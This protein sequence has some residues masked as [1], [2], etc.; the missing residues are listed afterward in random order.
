MRQPSPLSGGPHTG[1]G[2]AASPRGPGTETVE[3]PPEGPL[4]AGVVL[5]S[6]KEPAVGLP[7]PLPGLRWVSASPVPDL[8]EEVS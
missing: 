7:Q 3:P 1:W 2:Q 8:A 6:S 4:C 5:S